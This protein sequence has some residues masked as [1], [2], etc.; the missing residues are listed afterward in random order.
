VRGIQMPRECLLEVTQLPEALETGLESIT[1]VV[2]IARFVGVTI[3][4]EVNS[5]RVPRDCMLKVTQ[6]PEALETNSEVT[7]EVIQITRFIG[8]TV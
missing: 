1:E 6:L 8:V 4:S 7:A 5:I 3:R 2:Q